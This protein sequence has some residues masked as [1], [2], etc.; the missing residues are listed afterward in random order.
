MEQDFN[1]PVRSLSRHGFQVINQKGS[2]AKAV[3]WVALL[4]LHCESQ[5][6][7][8][9]FIPSAPATTSSWGQANS[10]CRKHLKTLQMLLQWLFHYNPHYAFPVLGNLQLQT[11]FQARKIYLSIYLSFL[12][13]DTLDTLLWKLWCV[14]QIWVSPQ[15]VPTE[16]GHVVSAQWIVSMAPSMLVHHALSHSVPCWKASFYFWANSPTW[17]L[18]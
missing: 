13:S 17:S 6:S 7:V 1:T 16:A 11:R 10:N 9:R 18:V 14:L 8:T 4:T 5:E 3:V 2:K 12:A 15:K